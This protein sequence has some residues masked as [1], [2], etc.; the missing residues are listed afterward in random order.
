MVAEQI[1]CINA[2]GLTVEMSKNGRAVNPD[3]AT[4]MC[5]AHRVLRLPEWHGVA[6]VAHA[7]QSI[8]GTNLLGYHVVATRLIS[9]TARENTID[10]FGAN[11][12]PMSVTCWRDGK[13]CSGATKNVAERHNALQEDSKPCRHD[14]PMRHCPAEC[15]KRLNKI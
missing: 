14:P 9:L 10:F 6:G 4:F 2:L 11:L 5:N 13:R 1:A 7:D 8:G 12:T 3:Q 15:A